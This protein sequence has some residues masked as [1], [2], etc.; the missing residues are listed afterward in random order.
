MAVTQRFDQRVAMSAQTITATSAPASPPP[1]VI[2]TLRDSRP[3][4]ARWRPLPPGASDQPT[5]LGIDA[6]EPPPPDPTGVRRRLVATPGLGGPPAGLRDPREW[7]GV[8]SIAIVQSLHGRRPLAQLERWLDDDVLTAVRFAARS[9]ERR[10]ADGL[11]PGPAGPP[12][13]PPAVRSVR[14]QCPVPAV[15]E[16]AVHLG[17]GRR[18]AAIALRLE[19]RY[20]RWLCTAL[21]LGPRELGS[22]AR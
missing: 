8:L 6:P 20:D 3:A 10:R 15:A 13:A 2:R 21:E 16:V 5:L 11:R 18:S 9:R 4:P 22:R 12:T 7:A 14:L 17:L 19:A 1:G